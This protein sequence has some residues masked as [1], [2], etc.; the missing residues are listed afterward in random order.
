MPRYP[1]MAQL[2]SFPDRICT[3]QNSL[4]LGS[5]AW[6]LVR[7]ATTCRTGSAGCIRRIDPLVPATFQRLST[8]AMRP[9]KRRVHPVA[10]SVPLHAAILLTQ[11][12]EGRPA[13][14]SYPAFASRPLTSDTSW[15]SP[16]TLQHDVRGI[17]LRGPYAGAAPR[18]F[19]IRPTCQSPNGSECSM[20]PRTEISQLAVKVT[21]DDH[22]IGSDHATVTLVST[23]TSNVRIAARPRC[24]SGSSGGR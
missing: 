19:P 14:R 8:L 2:G 3:T 4:P 13:W 16:V 18:C 24:R 6:L 1:S 11:T 22:I 7:P 21:A 9:R 23:P 15:R 12:E 5:G 20:Q 17:L 10:R